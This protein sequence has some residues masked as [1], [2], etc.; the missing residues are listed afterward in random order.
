MVTGTGQL[1]PVDLL[2]DGHRELKS[3]VSDL[4]SYLN[5]EYIGT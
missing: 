4:L 1:A 5:A 3:I 2:G